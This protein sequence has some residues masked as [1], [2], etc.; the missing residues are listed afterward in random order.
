MKKI[1]GSPVIDD[2]NR[3]YRSESKQ[4]SLYLSGFVEE[5]TNFM[6]GIHK[7]FY[8]NRKI[9]NINIFSNTNR[10]T[11]GNVS[12]IDRLSGLTGVK[13]LHFFYCTN[14]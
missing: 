3:F 7:V 8:Y 9:S 12:N 1:E 5:N 11:I 13:I 14:D 4:I 6:S 10:L 2:L